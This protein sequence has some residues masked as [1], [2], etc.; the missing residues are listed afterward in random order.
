[1]GEAS[2][3]ISRGRFL[4]Y[5]PRSS[6]RA[7]PYGSMGNG[8]PVPAEEAVGTI[9]WTVSSAPS[10]S[11]PRERGA[12]GSCSRRPRPR[13]RG[14]SESP[15]R[16]LRRPIRAGPVILW[17]VA[18]SAV[19]RSAL[20]D[21]KGRHRRSMPDVLQRTARPAE[22]FFRHAP[23]AIPRVGWTFIRWCLTPDKPGT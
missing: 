1:M 16:Y 12:L 3:A 6:T 10:S 11:T 15:P 14:P 23:G 5:L 9:M 7:A 2:V 19:A 17:P 20:V 22:P 13:T 8:V 21:P 18:I 4:D